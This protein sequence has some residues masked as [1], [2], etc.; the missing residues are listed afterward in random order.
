M[1]RVLKAD[2]RPSTEI[3]FD[4]LKGRDANEDPNPQPQTRQFVK[5]D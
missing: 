5:Q 1:Q 2:T 3:N 4:E